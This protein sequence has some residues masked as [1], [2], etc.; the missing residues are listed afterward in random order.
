MRPVSVTNIKRALLSQLQMDLTGTRRSEDNSNHLSKAV[1]PEKVH[2][3]FSTYER[4][5]V[6][7]CETKYTIHPLSKYEAHEIEERISKNEKELRELNAISGQ[8]SRGR[9]PCEGKRFYQV[10]KTKNFDKCNK[11]PV[12]QSASGIK[13]KCDFGSSKCD[14]AVTVSSTILNSFFHFFHFSQWVHSYFSTLR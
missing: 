1:D 14:D 13:I 12:Y 4:T 8:K 2:S 3:Y 7:D 9:E 5:V 10:T 11:M 6:G